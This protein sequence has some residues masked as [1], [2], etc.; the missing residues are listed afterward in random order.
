MAGKFQPDCVM[1]QRP[2]KSLTTSHPAAY[3]AGFCL[4]QDVFTSVKLELAESGSDLDANVLLLLT[5]LVER[6]LVPASGTF[7]PV[8]ERLMVRQPDPHGQML[9]LLAAVAERGEAICLDICLSLLW[10]RPKW[11]IGPAQR[12][13]VGK[14]RCGSPG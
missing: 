1:C 10:S 4:L 8:A 13:L 12:H 11:C 9:A 14:R 6:G 2:G 7:R 5:S 3:H